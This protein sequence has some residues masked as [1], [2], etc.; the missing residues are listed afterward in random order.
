MNS[1]SNRT[2]KMFHEMEDKVFIA[3]EGQRENIIRRHW[4]IFLIILILIIGLI[5]YIFFFKQNSN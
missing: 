2:S 5:Y 4:I 1:F 3:L